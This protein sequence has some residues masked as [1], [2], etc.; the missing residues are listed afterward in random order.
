MVRWNF[1]DKKGFI[2]NNEEEWW[3]ATEDVKMKAVV[4]LSI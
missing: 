4:N 3:F 1:L 2:D